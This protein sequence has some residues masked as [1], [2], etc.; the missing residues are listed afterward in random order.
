LRSN[1]VVIIG[2]GI[3]GLAAAIDLAVSGADVVVL[4]AAEGPG[5][6]MRAVDVDGVALD[7]GPTVL[8]MRETFDDLFA[9]AN[10]A[11]I[12][13]VT[14]K[15][16]TVLARHAWSDGEKLDLF[17]DIEQSARA[18]GAFAG[19][20]EARGFLEFTRRSR[21]IF[22]ALDSSFMHAQRPSPVSLVTAAGLRGLG[23]LTRISPFSTMWKAL[24]R[25]FR[26]PRL[27]QLFARY[28]TY[29][30]SSPF[31]A[32]ATLMLVAHAEQKG[33]WVVE[34]GMR[35]LADALALIACERGAVMRY[36]CGVAEIV[37]SHGRASGVRLSSGDVLPADAIVSNG[38]V[39]ALA[40]GLLGHAVNRAVRTTPR[41][42]RSLSALTWLIDAKTHGFPLLHHSIFFSRDYRA[43]FDDIFG[44]GRLPRDPT[45]YVCAQDRDD[46]PN[47]P[48]RDRERLLCL[49]NAPPIGDHHSF[50]ISELEQCRN[51][52]FHRLQ[53]CGLRIELSSASMRTVTPT[54][55]NR[56]YPGT[57]GALY[58]R[59]SHGWMAS[60]QRPGARSRIPGLY[61]AGGSTHPGPGIPMAATSGRLAAKAV[62]ADLA[63]TRRSNPM[64]M[65]GGMSTRSATTAS[66][67]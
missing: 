19:A 18:I 67:D 58:G 37:T 36:G 54:D 39:A 60:F 33:V 65:R 44:H 66:T 35:R 13:Y 26:D 43:E 23:Q 12:D 22:E 30:G 42:A 47:Q 40:C 17:A 62:I 38:D 46:A 8:T 21:E 34:G 49:V 3:G 32:P 6:K 10:A 63:S 52:T 59:T 45:I 56:L 15:P 7:G 2:A 64:A 50:S 31:D 28:A 25:F 61:L 53:S 41:A 1:R 24:G 20:T 55:F 11:L 4:E 48:L 9:D 16:L 29:C 14:L 5:G 51:R 27:R 57:G